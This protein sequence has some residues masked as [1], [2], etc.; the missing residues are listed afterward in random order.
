MKTF[1]DGIALKNPIIIALAPLTCSIDLLKRAE[2]NGA[3]GA[4]LELTF[5]EVLFPG[6][7]RSYSLPGRELLFGIDRRLNI[8]E[9]PE[10][11]SRS[12]AKV[13]LPSRMTGL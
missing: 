10:L 5:E 13:M 4:S 1:L 6:K 8:D 11:M 7:L 9:G 12:F 2:D 3:T